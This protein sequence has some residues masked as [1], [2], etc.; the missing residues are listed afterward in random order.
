MG[1]VIAPKEGVTLGGLEVC[2]LESKKK[3]EGSKNERLD[4][5]EGHIAYLEGVIYKLFDL[6]E[7]LLTRLENL[8]HI[9]TKQSSNFPEPLPLLTIFTYS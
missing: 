2:F 7:E 8:E 9:A 6:S 4:Q 5:L 3:R 1:C